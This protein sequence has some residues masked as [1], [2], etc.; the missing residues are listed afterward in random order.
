[1][2]AQLMLPGDCVAD[3]SVRGGI[4][5]KLM[6]SAAGIVAWRH[7][8]TNVVTVSIEAM[9]MLRPLFSG[10]VAVVRARLSY[11]SEKCARLCAPSLRTRSRG[12]VSG[13]RRAMEIEVTVE[14]E[15]PQSRDA[16]LVMRGFFKFVSLDAQHR[17]Q[18]IPRVRLVADD[19]Y[20]RFLAGHERHQR[21]RRLRQ[22]T[23]GRT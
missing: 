2:L 18:T 21:A 16:F 15:E 10:A 8:R 12:H 20:E 13:A 7:C 23:A 5:L 19:E 22:Q 4:V 11:V 1:M 3:G 6:D 9:D 14:A 17:S